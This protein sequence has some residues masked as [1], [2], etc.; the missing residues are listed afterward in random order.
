MV[1]YMRMT[2]RQ[3]IKFCDC[4]SYFQDTIDSL[5]MQHFENV[6]TT[7]KEDKHFDFETG[8]LLLKLRF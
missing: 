1:F 6:E 4:R 3:T 2:D 7:R 5:R 8:F